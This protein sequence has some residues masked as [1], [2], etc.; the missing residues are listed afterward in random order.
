MREGV[1]LVVGLAASLAGACAS[2]V[3]GTLGRGDAGRRDVAPGLNPDG[4]DPFR[5]VDAGFIAVDGSTDRGAWEQPDGAVFDQRYAYLWV[6]EYAFNGQNGALAQAEFRLVPRPEDP[7]CSYLS[8]ANWDVITCSDGAAPPDPHPRPFPNAG[9]IAI[10]GGTEPVSLRA[11]SGGQYP[12]WFEPEGIF[13]GPRTLT[14]SAPGTAS[15]PPLRLGVE[16]PAPLTLTSPVITPGARLSILTSADIV[17]AWQPTSARSVY[18]S[19]SATGTL[20]GAR[21]TVRVVAEF[22]GA[23]GRGVLPQRALRGLGVLTAVTTAQ[24]SVTPQ[25]LTTT[26]VGP[27]PVQ[28]TASGLE[29]EVEVELR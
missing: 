26:R 14:L 10:S 5:P 7:R 18:V 8:A 6:G 1:I 15:V 19:L 23:T 3:D 25:N 21:S 17:V 28:V 20:E 11:D 2:T 24:F 22:P 4:D 12:T 16:I 27:W 29:T 9:T 13:R